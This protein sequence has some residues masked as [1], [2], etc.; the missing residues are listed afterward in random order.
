MRP[1]TSAFESRNGVS[2]NGSL[3][4]GKKAPMTETGSVARGRHELL[5]EAMVPGANDLFFQTW[6]SG[7]FV[8]VLLVHDI[9]ASK[10]LFPQDSV[11]IYR[12]F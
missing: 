4:I 2:A 3:E 5:S 1:P 11:A 6:S 9:F 8:R 7:D 12:R 10:D